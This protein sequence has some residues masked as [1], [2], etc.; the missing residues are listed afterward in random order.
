MFKVNE[1][2][3]LVLLTV[4]ENLIIPPVGQSPEASSKLILLL[5]LE[6]D[7]LEFGVQL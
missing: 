4:S 6:F 7:C 2:M 3:N 1:L 5:I